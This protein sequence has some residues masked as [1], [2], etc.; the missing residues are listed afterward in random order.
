[1]QFAMTKKASALGITLPFMESL[2]CVDSKSGAM[3]YH[4]IVSKHVVEHMVAIK[5]F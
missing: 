3:L 2:V 5:P 4:I 1:M